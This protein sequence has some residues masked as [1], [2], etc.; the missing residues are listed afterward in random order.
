[1]CPHNPAV[2]SPGKVT[3]QVSFGTGALGNP[4][5]WGDYQ[6]CV[7]F[8]GKEW[9][10]RFPVPHDV[11]IEVVVD[12]AQLSIDAIATCGSAASVAQESRAGYQ[13]NQQGATYEILTGT[14]PNG[15]MPDILLTFDSDWITGPHASELWF[16]PDPSTRTS[17]IPDGAVDAMS[18]CLHELGH[19]FGFNGWRD[20]STGT[21]PGNQASYYDLLSSIEGPNFFFN[22]EKAIAVYGSAVPEN[23]TIIM[24]LGNEAP[25]P[26]SDLLDDVMKHG[27]W[28]D[29]RFNLSD[30]DL[31]ILADVGAPVPGSLAIQHICDSS[32][33]VMSTEPAYRKHVVNQS[34]G[35]VLGPPPRQV[36]IRRSP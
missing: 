25:R 13:V 12:V 32:V 31:A 3:F 6:N 5:R 36:A 7:L 15:A 8:A 30:L 33:E 4:A 17:P 28:R 24:H 2:S 29:Q 16:D 11:S 22:G 19:A 20:W 1:V 26:G 9:A 27:L 23:H 35:I 18:I 10:K 34:P 14:D 21:L